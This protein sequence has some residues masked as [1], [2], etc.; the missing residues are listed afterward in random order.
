MI[1]HTLKARVFQLKLKFRIVA[2]K[3]KK[4]GFM[5][6]NVLPADIPLSHCNLKLAVKSINLQNFKNT[7][8]ICLSF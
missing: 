4:H 6:K 7:A 3:D 8:T 2:G 5:V 1:E